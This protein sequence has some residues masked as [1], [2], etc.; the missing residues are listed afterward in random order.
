MLHDM[1]TRQKNIS[2]LDNMSLSDYPNMKQADRKK[3]HRE[4]RKLAYPEY[5]KKNLRN[6]EDL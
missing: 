6:A 1:L 4:V 2:T 3:M 5:Y